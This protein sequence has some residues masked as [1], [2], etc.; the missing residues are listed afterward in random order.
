MSIKGDVTIRY[1]LIEHAFNGVHFFNNPV[2]DL[3]PDL[4]HNLKVYGNTFRYIRDNPV[5][6]ERGAWNV[7]IYNNSFYNC[8]KWLSLEMSRSGYVYIFG[9]IGWFDDMPGTIPD[10]QYGGSVL[11]LLG[12]ADTEADG[13]HYIFHNSWYLRSSYI[14]G[15]HIRNLSHFNNAALYCDP[16]CHGKRGKIA[17]CEGRKSIFGEKPPMKEPPEDPKDQFKKKYLQQTVK[18]V[19]SHSTTI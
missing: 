13:P 17:H 9:N 6:P 1:N 10:D 2:N 14:K 16:G 12:G 7:W 4:N 11:K 8:H 5:E 15:Q 19:R 3:D 18:S